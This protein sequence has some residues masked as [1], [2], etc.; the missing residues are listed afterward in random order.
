M[1][2]PLALIALVVAPSLS[3]Q[4]ANEPALAPGT[5]AVR[6]LNA[7]D[8]PMVY[9]I[10]RDGVVGR[11]QAIP[12][13]TGLVMHFPRDS[14]TI[15]FEVLAS[16]RFCGAAV[17]GTDSLPPIRPPGALTRWTRRAGP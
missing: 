8:C 2:I 14:A 17:P 16:A 5:V 10:V 3:A 11:V 12:A 9:H 6:L 7:T 15:A 1:R 13:K 4:V